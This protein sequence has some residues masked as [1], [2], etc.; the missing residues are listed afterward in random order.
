VE[1]APFF[2]PS[3]S[4][5]LLSS[6]FTSSYALSPHHSHHLHQSFTTDLKLIQFT[7]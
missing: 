6:W 4:S 1:S 5:C 3:T 7:K 2:I